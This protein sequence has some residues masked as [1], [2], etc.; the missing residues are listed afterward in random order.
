MVGGAA[1]AR[2]NAIGATRLAAFTP[3]FFWV[4][5]CAGTTSLSVLLGALLVSS[6]AHAGRPLT[7]EDAGVIEEGRCQLEAWVDRSREATDTWIA[8]ACNVGLGIEWQLGAARSR[9]SGSARLAETYAQAKKSLRDLEDASPWG[10]ALVVG[11]TRRP[12][13]PV[14]RGWDHPFAALPLTVAFGDTLA[15]ASI[16]WSRDRS[17]QRD[18]TPWGIALETPAGE[19]LTLVG[20]A[21]GES[22]ARPFL[23]A[24]GRYSLIKDSLEIDLTV[25]ARP[26]GGRGER[27]VSLGVFWQSGRFMP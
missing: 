14:R 19:R 3:R 7:T 2:S 6:L 13:D 22:S 25:V 21:F 18:V 11:V 4:R 5:A 10:L 9:Q 26:G 12:Q 8:P 20:E 17:E 23:R 24:G 16:G 15:H 27:L 1:L